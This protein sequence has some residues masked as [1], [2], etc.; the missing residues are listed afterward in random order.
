MLCQANLDLSLKAETMRRRRRRWPCL[1]AFSYDDGIL[2]KNIDIIISF[3]PFFYF[4]LM[5]RILS[6]FFQSVLQM[7]PLDPG[8]RK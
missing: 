2:H 3:R 7:R 1:N 4:N 8:H 6:T 5:A